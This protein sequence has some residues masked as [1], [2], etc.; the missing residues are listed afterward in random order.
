MFWKW[1]IL[2]VDTYIVKVTLA[3]ILSFIARTFEGILNLL[4]II[5]VVD[6]SAMSQ[7]NFINIRS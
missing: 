5:N 4:L 3:L 6:F 2:N 1:L 7:L